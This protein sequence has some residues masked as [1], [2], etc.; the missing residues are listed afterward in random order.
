M[1]L[2][3]QATLRPKPID[4][5]LP[6]STEDSIKINHNII[7]RVCVFDKI[8]RYWSVITPLRKVKLLLTYVVSIIINI[9]HISTKHIYF[10]LIIKNYKSINLSKKY[11]DQ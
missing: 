6:K 10:K 4:T 7:I 1:P 2:Q 8:L 3:R 11:N 5:N 9:I